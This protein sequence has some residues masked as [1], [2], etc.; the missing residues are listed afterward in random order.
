MINLT[1]DGNYPSRGWVVQGPSPGKGWMITGGHGHTDEG[2][3]DLFKGRK[4][5]S[6]AVIGVYE[7]VISEINTIQG[8]RS[9]CLYVMS[10]LYAGVFRFRYFKLLLLYRMYQSVGHYVCKYINQ[11]AV[12]MCL[13]FYIIE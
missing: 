2:E 3:K 10:R 6:S 13:T 12:K 1:N 8:I 4:Q 11:F 5:E 7:R 9:F